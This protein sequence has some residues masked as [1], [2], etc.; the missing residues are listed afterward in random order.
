MSNEFYDTKSLLPNLHNF[1]NYQT[2]IDFLQEKQKS[3]KSR[4]CTKNVPFGDW[5]EMMVF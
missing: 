3:R 4:Y 2:F 1:P 5:I